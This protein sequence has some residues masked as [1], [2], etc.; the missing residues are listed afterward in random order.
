MK[1]NS[2]ITLCLWG[3][4]SKNP[5]IK[6][7]EFV[8]K[9]LFF[10]LPKILTLSDCVIRALFTKFDHYSPHSASFYPQIKKKESLDVPVSAETVISVHNI[11]G[12]EEGEEK[13]EIVEQASRETSLE[14]VHMKKEESLSDLLKQLSGEQIEKKDEEEVESVHSSR[15]VIES[16]YEIKSPEPVDYDEFDGDE[17][18]VDLRAYH[19]V[20]G[21]FHF[22]LLQMPPQPKVVRNWTITQLVEPPELQYM[23]YVIDVPKQ[24]ISQNTTSRSEAAVDPH[25]SD[26][27]TIA[28]KPDIL[29]YEGN[30]PEVAKEKK[31]VERPPILVTLRLPDDVYFCE[32]PQIVRWDEDEKIWR[33]DG[34]Q[35]KLYTEAKRL[36]TFRTCQFGTMAL[37]QD[38]HVNMPFQSWELRPRDT[39]HAQLTIIAA[40]VEIEIQ[41]KDG[42]VCLTQPDK[43]PEMQHLINRWMSVRD[44]I[45]KM[46]AAGVNVFPAEDSFKYVKIPDKNAT[47]EYR[48]YRQMA[49]VGSAMAFSWSKWNVDVNDRERILI[50]AAEHTTDEPLL[51]DDWWL[52][53]VTKKSCARLKMSEF[54]NTFNDERANVEFC[55]DLYHLTT[56]T[57]NETSAERIANTHKN[58]IETACQ[59]LTA[60][61]LITFA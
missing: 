8:E 52:C 60:T 21:I 33:T 29:R 34:L 35:D 50:Q 30:R 41:I 4:L 23:S 43:R 40:V 51:E 57:V 42:L 48:L 37:I 55:A 5:R 26:H 1:G 49:L 22:N 15:V 6:T 31:E 39:N 32:E 3:N 47:A 36:L 25:K 14:D 54:D 17:D 7:Y 10:E 19:T 46:R 59:L 24:D 16:D 9:G 61:R 53:M 28:A 11:D 2:S 12:E 20:G 45:K 56:S 38:A 18:T 27:D 58:F 44:L 13:E